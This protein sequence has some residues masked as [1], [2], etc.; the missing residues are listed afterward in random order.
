MTKASSLIR[1][2]V[3]A[4]LLL[5]ACASAQA[6]T[7]NFKFDKNGNSIGDYLLAL[8]AFTG[9]P[10]GPYSWAYSGKDTAYS[11]DVKVYRA[12]VLVQVYTFNSTGVG[13]LNVYTDTN[14]TGGLGFPTSFSANVVTLNVANISGTNLVVYN[15]TSG[16]PGYCTGGPYGY[17]EIYQSYT[18]RKSV[19]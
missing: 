9:S 16:Q 18:D 7:Y 5:L 13:Y 15:P 19:V 6:T 4:S 2:G 11:G 14:H 12:G 17:G 8:G 1:A 3:L 10:G